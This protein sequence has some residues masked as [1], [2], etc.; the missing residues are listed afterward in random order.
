MSFNRAFNQALIMMRLNRNYTS[1]A[2]SLFNRGSK[3]KQKFIDI[4]YY[5]SKRRYLCTYVEKENNYAYHIVATDNLGSTVNRTVTNIS[6]EHELT[7]FL[8]RNWR[9]S[10][11]TDIAN[12]F[13]AASQYC[14]DHQINLS[15]TRFDSLVDG[16]MDHCENLTDTELLELLRCLSEYPRCDSYLAHNF[17]DVWSCL[18]DMCCWRIPKRNVETLITFADMWYKWQ[19]AKY[20]DFIYEILDNLAKKT[21]KLTK[22]QLLHLFFLFNVSRRRQVHFEYEYAIEKYI[23]EMTVDQM[24]VIALGY[25]KTKSKIKLLPISQAM[26][27]GVTNSC[28]DIHEISL[29]AIM[30]TLRFSQPPKVLNDIQTMLEKLYPELDRFS[31]VCCLHIALILTAVVTPNYNI[32]NKVSEIL[33]KDIKTI[34]LKEI[35]RILNVLSMFNYHP[36]TVPRLYEKAFEELHKDYRSSEIA[37]HPRPFLSA[38]HYLSLQEIYSYSY[39]DNI[40]DAEYIN[41]SF[42]IV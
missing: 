9:N 40:L 19:M 5:L 10:N 4:Q 3:F 12:A 28:K 26:I 14:K 24:A 41:L 32:L 21:D 31:N 1:L 25:F 20:S 13:K 42:G 18:D 35:E 27:K 7:T 33:F 17:H 39:L 37:R 23:N 38:L 16:L 15:D 36:K 29:T 6:N 8:D 30:K 2:Y 11:S 22:E 34:R